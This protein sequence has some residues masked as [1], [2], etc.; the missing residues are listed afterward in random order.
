MY[1]DI[2]K[3]LIKKTEDN[4][5]V[6]IIENMQ[7]ITYSE[8]IIDNIEYRVREYIPN[9]IHL[10]D[11]SID[12]W[13]RYNDKVFLIKNDKYE[14]VKYILELVDATTLGDIDKI[15]LYKYTNKT[16]NT[17]L[18]ENIITLLTND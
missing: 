8:T 3:L 14:M 18:I 9:H 17:N 6:P 7:C 1:Y 5:Y 12:K 16:I 10:Y 13:F 2:T 15:R 4:D 11:L